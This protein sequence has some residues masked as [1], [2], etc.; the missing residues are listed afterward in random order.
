VRERHTK[1]SAGRKQIVTRIPGQRS[2]AAPQ[3]Q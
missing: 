1:N 3:Y 2:A